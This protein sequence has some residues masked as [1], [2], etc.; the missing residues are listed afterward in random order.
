MNLRDVIRTVS[1]FP[2]PG[3]QFRDITT[4]V[5]DPAAYRQAV[6]WMRESLAGIEVDMI[7]GPEARG[8][9]FSAPL[10]YAMGAGLALA[11]KPGKLPAD[12]IECKYGLEYGEDALEMHRDAIQPGQRVVVADDLLA[13][14]GTAQAVCKLVEA[15]GGQVVAVRF[16]IELPEL[17]GRDVLRQ[18]DLQSLLEF[19]GD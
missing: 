8:Y 18:Y 16:V 3:V 12:V 14:G 10:A 1:D 13:T 9:L 7:A 5:G 4:L 17:K 11:R 2:R 6:D 19:E 15:L